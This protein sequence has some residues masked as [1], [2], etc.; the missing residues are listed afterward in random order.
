MMIGARIIALEGFQC[1]AKGVVYHFL[2]SDSDSNRVKLVH[3]NY[4]SADITADLLMLPQNIFEEAL[5]NK[6]LVE[7]GRDDYPPWLKNIQ[8]YSISFLEDRRS[9]TKE[10]YNQKSRP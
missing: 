6:A 4:A 5:E 10:N 9:S 8:G 2:H 1:L 3:F 7:D